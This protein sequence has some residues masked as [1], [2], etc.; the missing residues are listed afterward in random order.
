MSDQNQTEE[1]IF[2][3]ALQLATVQERMTYVQAACSHDAELHGRVSELLASRDGVN[4]PLDRQYTA[5][6]KAGP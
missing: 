6:P 2:L 5:G 4:G 3:A 1:P